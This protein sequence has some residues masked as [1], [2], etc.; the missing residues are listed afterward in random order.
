MN[1]NEKKGTQ[2][3]AHTAQK[4]VRRLPPCR[5]GDDGLE[6]LSKSIIY[7]CIFF[8]SPG[9]T[10]GGQTVTLT[11]Q[12]FSDDVETIIYESN[13]FMHFLSLTKWHCWGSDS[14]LDRS[15]FLR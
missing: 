7:S 12:G 5:T 8:L 1:K 14:D 10:A 15:R 13:I 11:G 6:L 4:V 2:R 3:E 9:G